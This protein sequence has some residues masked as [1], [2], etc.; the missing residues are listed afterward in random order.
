M[1]TETPS[2]LLHQKRPLN[3]NQSVVFLRVVEEVPAAV[4]QV[5]EVILCSSPVPRLFAGSHLVQQ[6]P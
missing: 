6:W 3:L 4:V 5:E 2:R 1:E